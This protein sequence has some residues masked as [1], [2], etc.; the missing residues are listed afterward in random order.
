MLGLRLLGGIFGERLGRVSGAGQFGTKL[1]RAALLGVALL[2]AAAFDHAPAFARGPV[3][4]SVHGGLAYFHQAVCERNAGPGVARCLAHVRTDSQGNLLVVRPQ[5]AGRGVVMNAA[6]TPTDLRSAYKIS[7]M[8]SFSTVVAVIDA[9]G[10]PNA[11]ADLAVY[12]STFGLTPCTRTNGCLIQI[13]QNGGT[14]Y[15][16]YDSGWAQEQA[17][18]LQMVSVTCPNCKIMLVQAKSANNGDLAAAVSKAIAL[19]ANVVSNSYGGDEVGVSGYASAYS[20]PGV[21]ITASAGDDGYGPLFPA[22]APGVIAV[23]G[24]TLSKASNSRG[25][26]ETVWSYTGSGCSAVFAKPVW[27]TDKLCTARMVADIAAVADPGT[28]VYVYGPTG[29]NSESGWLIFGGTS[30]GAPL[31][32]GIY[33]ATGAKPNGAAKIWATPSAL[34]D[35]TSGSNGKCGGTYFCN[36]GPGYDGPTGMGTPAGTGA[37]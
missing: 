29:R 36:A 25:W 2:G 26:S 12:R 23:G 24:T 30:V 34:N 15:P 5:A 33:G 6:Y 7:A 10:Y 8:G 19:G 37:F 28:G 20:H 11:Q 4:V 13:D 16:K 22:S 21:A 18:D 9:Y 14:N 27:Q 31:I 32:A 1:F 35:I 17:L 3:Q